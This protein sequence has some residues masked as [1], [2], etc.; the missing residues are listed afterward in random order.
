[1]V[2]GSSWRN[3]GAAYEGA[4]QESRNAGI[5]VEAFVP[6]AWRLAEMSLQF[7]AEDSPRRASSGRHNS[8]NEQRTRR[9]SLRLIFRRG[10]NGFV[11]AIRL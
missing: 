2:F 3:R 4:N 1:M 6:N 11:F 9:L 7:S 5:I 8:E 10:G